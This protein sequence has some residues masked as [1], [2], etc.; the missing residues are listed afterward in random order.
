MNARIGILAVML[1]GVA[2]DGS[3]AF[4]T[5]SP[6][7][8]WNASDSVPVGLY[9]VHSTGQVTI[10][11][12]VAI[13]P[14]PSLARDLH[15]GGYLPR[16]VPMLKHVAALGGQIVCRRGLV[17][18]VEGDAV[19]V[20]Q[21]CDRRGRPLHVWQGCHVLARDEFFPLNAAPDS[22]D[23]RYFGSLPRSAI[24]GEASLLWTPKDD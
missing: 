20:A 11:D 9:R 16:G 18:T 15:E 8:V 13:F 1:C 5:S 7:L 6:A 22:L 19:A 23:G 17:V 21:E 4:G 24:V 14:P 12:L 2:L 3:S 10:N